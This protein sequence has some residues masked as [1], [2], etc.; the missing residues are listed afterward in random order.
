MSGRSLKAF[1][2][3]R[4]LVPLTG[5]CLWAACSSEPTDY[6][7][8]PNASAG[9]GTA[10]G[11]SHGAG[12]GGT[13]TD[14]GGSG[15]AT[16]GSGTM[17]GGSGAIAGS[18]PV[19]GS[20]NAE[21]GTTTVGGSGGD[22]AV[23]GTA[24]GGTK[25]DGG[26]SGDPGAGETGTGGTT[27]GGEAGTPGGTAGESGSGAGGTGGVGGG[28]G[29]LGGSSGGI[30]GIG[31]SAGSTGGKGGQP[32]TCEDD[33]TC[34][35]NQY[36]K[37]TSCDAATGTC[38]P[39]GGPC[40]GPDAALNPVCG[41]DHLTY[42]TACVA[43]HEGVNVAASGECQAG[44]ATCSRIAGSG[45]SCEP[46][47]ARAA[48]YRTRSVCNS[49]AAPDEGVCWVLPETCPDEDEAQL[50]C[51]NGSPT[52]RGLCDALEQKRPVIRN[53]SQCD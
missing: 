37:K 22:A 12:V 16:A 11:G 46:H 32:G 38:T 15:G 3:I 50:D 52:C 45:D 26:M 43:A 47:R 6:F 10:T 44:A 49:S 24:Q 9:K 48:C 42:Y 14:S 21:G 1:P 4:A 13:G 39:R 28:S 5:L 27:M 41:C 2:S 19:G 23:G 53:S 35:P 7:G 34:A 51:N 20:S 40:A 29:G 17:A 30:G 33:E 18:P 25:P 31:G 36:C 8:T